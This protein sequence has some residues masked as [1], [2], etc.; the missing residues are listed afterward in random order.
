MRREAAVHARLGD[1]LVSGRIDLLAE[2]DDAFII[3]DHKSFPG[4]RPEQERRAVRYGSQLELYAQAVTTATAQ[5]C[6][7]LWVHMPL[8]GAL[9]RVERCAAT[10]VKQSATQTGSQ[11]KVLTPPE[12]KS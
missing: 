6:P 3:I 5:P 12:R 9:V 10:L 4:S 8:V 1:Q 11:Q 2:H 7:Q